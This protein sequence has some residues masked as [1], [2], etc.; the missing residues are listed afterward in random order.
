MRPLFQLLIILLFCSNTLWAQRNENLDVLHY[1]LQLNL[2]RIQ[3]KQLSGIATLSAKILGSNTKLIALDLLKL[4]V[5]QVKCNGDSVGFSQSDSVVR[6]T[7][8]KEYT[9]SDTLALVI[10]YS[11]SPVTDP[12][13][14]GFFFSGN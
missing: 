7:L 9:P 10:Q 3:L 6:I 11:G 12:K 1:D 2:Q 8:N 5:S 13:W 4:Q 14:G